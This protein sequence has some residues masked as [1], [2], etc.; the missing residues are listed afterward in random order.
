MM[1]MYNVHTWTCMH[2]E[3][4]QGLIFILYPYWFQNKA[5]DDVRVYMYMRTRVKTETMFPR[6]LIAPAR[7]ENFPASRTEDC[8]SRL[9]SN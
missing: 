1:Y 4:S 3:R 7:T 9:H 5:F 8:K 6:V 2:K